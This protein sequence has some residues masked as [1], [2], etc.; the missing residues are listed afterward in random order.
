[1]TQNFIPNEKLL[2]WVRIKCN[3]WSGL[4]IEA[5]WGHFVVFS[6]LW[7]VQVS[8]PSRLYINLAEKRVE[9]TFCPLM[10]PHWADTAHYSGLHCMVVLDED[11]GAR[12][13]KTL[14]SSGDV[15]IIFPLSCHITVCCSADVMV[16]AFD[17]MS[18]SPTTPA[19]W[20]RYNNTISIHTIP[21]GI[22]H[23]DLMGNSLILNNYQ[24]Q[25]Q[26]K[27]NIRLLLSCIKHGIWADVMVLFLS[28]YPLY[29]YSLPL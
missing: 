14:A 15:R 2:N 29:P 3:V 9:C 25:S 26:N 28:L 18:G 27:R 22:L 12:S 1:M 7:T 5:F 20:R 6:S 4:V 10:L 24:V 21:S 16:S 8:R 13:G 11:P 17:W 19:K 23:E